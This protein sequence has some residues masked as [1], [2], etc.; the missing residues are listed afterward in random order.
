MNGASDRAGRGV[1]MTAWISLMSDG[2]EI[3]PS[4]ACS[5]SGRHA[6]MSLGQKYVLLFVFRGSLC[7][8]VFDWSWYLPNF[9]LMLANAV[10]RRSDWRMSVFVLVGIGL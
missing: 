5:V 1:E 9:V 3:Q 4:A 8:F 10:V 7:I 6:S 2:L